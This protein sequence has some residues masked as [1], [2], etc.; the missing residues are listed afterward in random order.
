MKKIGAKELTDILNG[1][2]FG[3]VQF[4]AEINLGSIESPSLYYNGQSSL[5]REEADSYELKMQECTLKFK[6]NGKATYYNYADMNPHQITIPIE[7]GGAKSSLI[8]DK[9][10]NIKY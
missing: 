9:I 4:S 2:F 1:N 10:K 3:E 5:T 8:L 6:K 7:I